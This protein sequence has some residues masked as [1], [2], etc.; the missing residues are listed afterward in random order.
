MQG[1]ALRVNPITFTPYFSEST[2]ESAGMFHA[3]TRLI[4]MNKLTL[5]NKIASQLLDTKMTTS[6]QRIYPQFWPVLEHWRTR[7]I[8]HPLRLSRSEFGEAPSIWAD[9]I[10]V[11]L[12][13]MSRRG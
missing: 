13:T 11:I 5:L 10:D 3:A 9:L 12:L 4:F 7:G 8:Y 1:F 2:R 6:I